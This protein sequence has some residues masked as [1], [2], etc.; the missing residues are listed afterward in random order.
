MRVL[1][2]FAILALV[3]IIALLVSSLVLAENKG[4]K[5]ETW[6]DSPTTTNMWQLISSGDLDELK[7]VLESNPEYASVRASDGRG[8]LFWAYE[9]GRKE[10]I[11]ELVK[12]GASEEERDA[13]GKTPKEITSVGP[14]S[15]QQQ[16]QAQQEAQMNAAVN[17]DD[18]DDDY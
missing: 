8:P 1:S 2:T 4:T 11:D 12:A 17:D 10:I 15:F 14:T 13:D 3:A 16:Q 5:T 9:Y 6:A 7:K 18:D